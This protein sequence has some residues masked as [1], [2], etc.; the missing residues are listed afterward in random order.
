MTDLVYWQTADTF[1]ERG[2]FWL[3]AAG[4]V[5]AA[6]AALAGLTDV[7]GERRIRQQNDA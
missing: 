4:L 7:V 1:W 6:F 2:S 5:M 3:I